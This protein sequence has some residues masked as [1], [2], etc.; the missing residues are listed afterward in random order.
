VI[1]QAEFE[2]LFSGATGF[3]GDGGTFQRMYGTWLTWTQSRKE[4]VFMVA[5]TNSVEALP[6][7]ALRK[8][9]IDEIFFIDLPNHNE[10]KQIFEIH[11]SKRGWDP[12]KYNIDTN[13]LA[14]STPN[15]NGSEIE[16]IIVEGLIIKVKEKGF[17]KENPPTTENFISAIPL[18]RT[19][20]ELNPD[21]STKIR[22]WAKER[23]VIFANKTDSSD[24]SGEVREKKS[25]PKR[26][27][28]IDE[29]DI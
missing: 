14:K 21:E 28:S 11:L 2:K 25:I 20:Y 9:R 16:Q 26:T 3:Q 27:I 23:N 7:P 12:D 19:S 4:D 29:G 15:R 8:G 18:V 1:T 5:T 6:P 22:E 10:R 17:G 13:V 24:S